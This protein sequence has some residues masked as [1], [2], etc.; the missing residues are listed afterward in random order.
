M[1]TPTS[2]PS[3]V[4]RRN[5]QSQCTL[6]DVFAQIPRA[7]EN[8]GQ[9]DWSNPAPQLEETILLLR[10]ALEF[11]WDSIDY[12]ADRSAPSSQVARMIALTIHWLSQFSLLLDKEVRH[13]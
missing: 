13:A 5:H 9:V 4:S 1:R 10:M 12:N 11:H 6:A 7:T 2:S 3:A 8:R